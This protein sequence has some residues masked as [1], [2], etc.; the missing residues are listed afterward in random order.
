MSLDVFEVVDVVKTETEIVVK[1][2]LNGASKIFE[3]HFPSSPVVPGVLQ[4][5][6]V[7]DI[8][9][10][11]FNKTFTIDSMSRCKFLA[12]LTPTDT[13][14]IILNITYSTDVLGLIK[15]GVTGVFGET[16][17]LKFNAVCK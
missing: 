11:E 1:A 15:I 16:T 8:L 9:S 3:G 4:L 5:Q 13:K 10:K 17:F 6:F 12:V 2:S 14:E 7:R